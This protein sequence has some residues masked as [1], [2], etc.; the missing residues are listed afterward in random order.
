MNKKLVRLI[1]FSLIIALTL[2]ACKLKNFENPEDPKVIE[3]K[4]K[5]KMNEFNKLLNNSNIEVA[6]KYLD[7]NIKGMDTER[8][9]QLIYSMEEVA[10]RDINKNLERLLNLDTDKE[11]NKL[12]KEGEILNKEQI[13]NIKNQ[14]L[15]KLLNNEKLPYIIKKT[16]GQITLEVNYQVFLDYKECIS[17]EMGKFMAIKMNEYIFPSIEEGKIIQDYDKLAEKIIFIEEYME[18]PRLLEGYQADIRY[19]EALKIYRDN[20][21]A[22]FVGAPADPIYNNRK[23]KDEVISSYKTVKA[24]GESNLAMITGKYYNFLEANNFSQTD[25]SN[26]EAMM[27]VVDGVNGLEERYINENW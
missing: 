20:L 26:H 5:G 8:S 18:M 22:Y 15:K 24:S 11:L 4:R 23:V 12:I 27:A 14:E 13:K 7:E 1:V 19:E 10:L 16:D 6:F 2:S 21:I 3:A 9:D 17:P 25:K